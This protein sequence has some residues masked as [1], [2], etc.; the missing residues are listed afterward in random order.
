MSG[1]WRWFDGGSSFVIVIVVSI[2]MRGHYTILFLNFQVFLA[3]LLPAGGVLGL[4][5]MLDVFQYY[6]HSSK[7]CGLAGRTKLRAKKGIKYDSRELY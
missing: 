4:S 6:M 7:A 5:M 2:I 3:V 1:G